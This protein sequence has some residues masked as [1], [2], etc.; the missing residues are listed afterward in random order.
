MSSLMLRGAICAAAM[1]FMPL[2]LAAETIEE[3][4]VMSDAAEDKELGMFLARDYA[5]RGEYLDAIATL[6]RVLAVHPKFDEARLLHAIFL[7]RIDDTLGAAVE[8]DKLRRKK[9]S[10]AKWNEA[11]AQCG[12]QKAE[13]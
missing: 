9:Y 13:G 10:D 7:C 4:D 2:P 5:S 8:F 6:E 11:L 1:S 12:F 3:L